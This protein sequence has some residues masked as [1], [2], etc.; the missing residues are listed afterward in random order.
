MHD[1]HH[2]EMT[3]MH[4]RHQSD[5]KGMHE[6]H[7]EEHMGMF[8]AHAKE[9]QAGGAGG[10]GEASSGTPKLGKTEGES[11][12]GEALKGGDKG[13]KLGRTKEEGKGGSEP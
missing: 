7:A 4:G 8:R 5:M 3:E 11:H 9:L 6:R 10:M 1:R 2:D 13:P 12:G